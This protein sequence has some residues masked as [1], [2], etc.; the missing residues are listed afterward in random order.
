LGSLKAQ[1][2]IPLVGS[3]FLILPCPP[4]AIPIV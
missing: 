4:H 1:A 2:V 3:V